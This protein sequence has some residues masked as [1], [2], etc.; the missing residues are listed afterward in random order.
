MSYNYTNGDGVAV[1][2]VTEPNGD[3]EPVANLEDAVVQIKKYLNDPI[4]GPAALVTLAIPSGVL[5]P[6]AMSSLPAGWL[7][8]DGTAVSRTTYAALFAAIGTIWGSGNGTT[9]FNIPNF[10][11]RTL[12]GI[13]TGTAVDATAWSLAQNKGAET[14]SLTAAE[15]GEHDH[16]GV[17]TAAG[18]TDRGTLASTFSLDNSANTDT[19]GSGDPHN[20]LQPSVGVVW[21]IK[22]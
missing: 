15:N 1:L 3:T 5:W 18:D 12:V 8:C 20:N 2:L 21:A 10:A 4:A 9:T 13:G 7:A 19:S 14:H 6:F 17:P 11:G 22:I 16:G